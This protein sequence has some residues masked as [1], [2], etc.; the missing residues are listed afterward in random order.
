MRFSRCA[1]HWAAAV[2]HR[3]PSLR[4]R[5]S[6][7]VCYFS[8]WCHRACVSLCCYC[9]SFCPC[10][11]QTLELQVQNTLLCFSHRWNRS[12]ARFSNAQGTP[13][14]EQAGDI[15]ELTSGSQLTDQLAASYLSLCVRACARV[16]ST[17]GGFAQTEW[18]ARHTASC[19]LH[20]LVTC[21]EG[22]TCILCNFFLCCVLYEFIATG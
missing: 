17:A 15:V 20:T 12:S 6:W 4:V 3:V 14:W 5:A 2:H 16:W 9:C 21:L 8:A 7:P 19:L 10:S 1:V 18:H 11:M 13:M 22:S